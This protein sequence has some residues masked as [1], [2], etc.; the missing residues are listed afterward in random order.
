MAWH[1]PACVT[2]LGTGHGTMSHILAQVV[3]SWHESRGMHHVSWIGPWPH[4][5]GVVAPY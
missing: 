2:C 5:M 4:G 3:A 1:E